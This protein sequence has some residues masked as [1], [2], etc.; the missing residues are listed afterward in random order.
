MIIG[1]IRSYICYIILKY[2]LGWG[3]KKPQNVYDIYKTEAKN[4]GFYVS[5]IMTYAAHLLDQSYIFI[6]N[7]KLR[8]NINE[9]HMTYI[10]KEIEKRE[11]HNI[12]LKEIIQTHKDNIL[13]PQTENDILRNDIEIYKRLYFN[14]I[15]N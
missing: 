10:I 13:Q 7:I 12:L 9:K 1:R 15:K 3:L 4:I 6:Y 14:A 5:K 2:I 8:R 11:T